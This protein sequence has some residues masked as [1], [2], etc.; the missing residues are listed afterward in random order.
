MEKLEN[1]SEMNW[2]TEYEI[3]KNETN[4]TKVKDPHRAQLL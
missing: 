3:E 4:Q 1:I 2:S